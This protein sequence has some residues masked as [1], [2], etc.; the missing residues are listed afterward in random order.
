MKG[1]RFLRGSTAENQAHTGD[2]GTVTLDIDRNQIRIHDGVTKGGHSI[3][4]VD[5]IAL[6]SE[7]HNVLYNGCLRVQQEGNTFVMGAG[8]WVYTADGFL[9]INGSDAIADLTLETIVMDGTGEA[10]MAMVIKGRTAPTEPGGFVFIQWIDDVRALAG[11]EIVGSMLISSAE[12]TTSSLYMLQYF[13]SEDSSGTSDQPITI[14]DDVLKRRVFPMT[15]PPIVGTPEIGPRAGLGFTFQ[16]NFTEVLDVVISEI[17]LELGVN[18]TPFRY[19]P[20]DQEVIA[21][22]R[23]YEKSY[24]IEMPAGSVTLQDA[25]R[26]LD[27]NDS[28]GTGATLDFRVP[29]K[30][31][32]TMKFYTP[33]GVADKAHDYVDDTDVDINQIGVG[34][35]RF[36]VGI[37]TDAHTNL[38][39]GFHWIADGRF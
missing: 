9:C 7:C 31:I 15:L 37:G 4:G 20:I 38:N 1:F 32:P 12:E 26:L 2:L 16:L 23:F 36:T 22:Q 24:S 35:N 21:A 29:K 10:K 8:A 27:G 11:Q 34:T 17:Q 39:V 5:E 28:M 19:R 25:V 30:W 3:A 14:I 13:D 18:P 6:M 33:D